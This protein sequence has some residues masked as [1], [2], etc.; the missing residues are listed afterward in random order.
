MI[1]DFG[2]QLLVLEYGVAAVTMAQAAGTQYCILA[3]VSAEGT[4]TIPQTRL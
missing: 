1:V 2:S 3:T 4:Q